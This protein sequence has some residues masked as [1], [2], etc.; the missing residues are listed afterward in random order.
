MCLENQMQEE[1]YLLSMN[2]TKQL[3]YQLLV[4]T[5]NTFIVYGQQEVLKEKVLEK[6]YQNMQ[7][8]MQKIKAKV[9]Y[10]F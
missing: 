7:L 2:Q 9:V 1:N 3:G 8:K 4:K 5:M 6:N 10:V